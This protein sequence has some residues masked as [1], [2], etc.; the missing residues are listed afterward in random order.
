MLGRN[1]VVAAPTAIATAILIPALAL[2]MMAFVNPAHTAAPSPS[3]VAG[4]M[5]WESAG[6]NA[7]EAGTARPA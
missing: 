2:F 1:R 3:A 7:P 6:K 5:T 4:D